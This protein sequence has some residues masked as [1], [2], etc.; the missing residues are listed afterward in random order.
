MG[1]EHI[2]GDVLVARD[3]GRVVGPSQRKMSFGRAPSPAL[4]V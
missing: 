3:A 4:P 2:A 1:V